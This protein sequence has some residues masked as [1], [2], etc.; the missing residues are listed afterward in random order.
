MNTYSARRWR[1]HCAC[2]Q[3]RHVLPARI[4]S[5]TR[6]AFACRDGQG[7]RG[8]N[9]SLRRS[10]DSSK[11]VLESCAYACRRGDLSDTCHAGCA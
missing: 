11:L 6:G 1:L 10:C 5:K 2:R 8:A 7:S 3:A 4:S 9:S